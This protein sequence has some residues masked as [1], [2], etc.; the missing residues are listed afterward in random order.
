MECYWNLTCLSRTMF[1]FFNP[2]PEQTEW[3]WRLHL[4]GGG[5]L[6]LSRVGLGGRGP[7]D[8]CLSVAV[9]HFPPEQ[10]MLLVAQ[11]QLGR[12]KAG[13]S[14]SGRSEPWPDAVS[15]ARVLPRPSLGRGAG[16]LA[17]RPA[18]SGGLSPLR[19]GAPAF[20]AAVRLPQPVLPRT[21]PPGRAILR[22]AG[23]LGLP[24][25]RPRR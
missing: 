25:S 22:E 6:L 8:V 7:G 15:S 20:P 4:V 16:A 14:G 2:S 17:G 1:S 24:V 11:P 21:R 10:L 23:G 12:A 3:L 19:G 18:A 9:I 13:R 5:S